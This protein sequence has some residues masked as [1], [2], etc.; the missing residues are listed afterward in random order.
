MANQDNIYQMTH[1]APLIWSHLITPQP[2]HTRGKTVFKTSYNGVFLLTKE[3]PD[4]APIASKMQALAAKDLPGN[5]TP[6]FPGL[7][8]DAEG[9]LSISGDNVANAAK[10]A[11]KDREWARG[12]IMF[13]AQSNVKT[14]KGDL[15]MPP[16]LVVLLNGKYVNYGTSEAPRELAAKFFYSGVLA[17]GT[18]MFS[19]YEGFGGGVTAYLNEVLSLNSGERIA[20]G[21]DAE[22]KYGDAGKFSQYTGH[23]SNVD[24][25]GTG[26]TGLV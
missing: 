7:D 21:P 25:V 19:S 22:E 23:V 12:K 26:L 8:R 6:S 10:A 20:G 4:W 11:G 24:P 5:S 13:K 2:E 18:F 14:L 9:K 3:H 16:R 15:L 17:V 1:P